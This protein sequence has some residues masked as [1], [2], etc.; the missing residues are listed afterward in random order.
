MPGVVVQ[1]ARRIIIQRR[2][3]PRR[4]GLA[5]RFGFH[6]VHEVRVAPPFFCRVI[7]PTIQ[8]GEK[9]MMKALMRAML[10]GAVVAVITG[11]AVSGAFADGASCRATAADKKLAGAAKTSFMTKCEKDAKSRCDT[12]ATDKK[13]AGAARTSF[14]KKCV[15][16][17][18]GS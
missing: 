9:A 4:G 18:V 11:A 15:S 12:A 3:T 14:N 5:I 7:L 13:L 8:G 16:D 17:A 1:R 10:A 6:D 2:R